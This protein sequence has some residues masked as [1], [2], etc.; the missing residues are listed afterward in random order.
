MAEYLTRLL[1]SQRVMRA[2]ETC[3]REYLVTSTVW[4]PSVS[5]SLTARMRRNLS[6]RAL[7]LVP[8]AR[9]FLTRRRIASTYWPPAH[10]STDWRAPHSPRAYRWRYRSTRPSL[11]YVALP[12]ISSNSASL[13]MASFGKSSMKRRPSD[14]CA[15]TCSRNFLYPPS[16]LARAACRRSSGMF[17]A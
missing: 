17:G 13:A 9:R 12:K 8:R 14:N 15:A 4:S 16:A 6:K 7:G 1:E 2:R 5:R 11:L 10:R 3:V